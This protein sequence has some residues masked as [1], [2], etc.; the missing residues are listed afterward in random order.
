MVDLWVEYKVAF[1]LWQ[2]VGITIFFALIVYFLRR[3]EEHK[4]EDIELEL[5]SKVV[6][7]ENLRFEAENFILNSGDEE[8]INIL[9]RAQANRHSYIRILSE[10]KNKGNETIAVALGI[11]TS[12]FKNT[13]NASIDGNNIPKAVDKMAS[14]LFE[15]PF[16]K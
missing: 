9:K 3:Q 6:E 4:Q 7:A 1:P 14:D 11:L 2:A 16:K 10:G 13:I 8:A 12:I 15:I 5:G